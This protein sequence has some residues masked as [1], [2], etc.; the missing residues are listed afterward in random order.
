M[1]NGSL[2][3]DYD[4]FSNVENNVD[5]C[6]MWFQQQH[7]LDNERQQQAVEQLGV[8]DYA[9][10]ALDHIIGRLLTKIQHASHVLHDTTAMV[11]KDPFAEL[12]P[13]NEPYKYITTLSPQQITVVIHNGIAET[14]RDIIGTIGQEKPN[15]EEQA[16]MIEADTDDNLID[17]PGIFIND[18]ETFEGHL[19]KAP[20]L[21]NEAIRLLELLPAGSI[22]YTRVLVQKVAEAVLDCANMPRE[23]VIEDIQTMRKRMKS[24]QIFQGTEYST[25]HPK[26]LVNTVK[27]FL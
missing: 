20:L 9:V 3:V 27:R 14:V 1:P 6:T 23:S 7:Y 8:A 19:K 21:S 16:D 2:K 4:K 22:D 17:S 12:H 10:R 26:T 5:Y 15:L 24:F 13:N 25:L 11:N 18:E